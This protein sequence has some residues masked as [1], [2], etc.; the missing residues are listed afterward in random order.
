MTRRGSYALV[1]QRESG[2]TIRCQVAGSSPAGGTA[3]VALN[4]AIYVWLPFEVAAAE[5]TDLVSG[6]ILLQRPRS[7]HPG[8]TGVYAVI[9]QLVERLICNQLVAGSIPAGSSSV[10]PSKPHVY[11]YGG[12][13]IRGWHPRYSRRGQQ[14]M[15]VKH[16]SVA[17]LE[18]RPPVKRECAG[19]IPA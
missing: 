2:S 7:W 17:Q 4:A 19:S 3:F 1:A 18:E 6:S 5:T 11:G 9:A 16:G 12:A 13:G 8:K 14:P 10:S 15:S